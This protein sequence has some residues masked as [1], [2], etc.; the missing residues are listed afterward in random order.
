MVGYRRSPKTNS[1]C[2]GAQ[3]GRLAVDDM[4]RSECQGENAA[5]F[6]IRSVRL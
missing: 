5:A 4:S 3:Y 1:L 2:C 6:F